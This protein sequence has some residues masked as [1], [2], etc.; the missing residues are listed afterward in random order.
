MEIQLQ[1]AE[2]CMKHPTPHLLSNNAVP[3]MNR[4]AQPH[5]S[6][7]VLP[8]MSSNVPPATRPAP[9]SSAPP[10]MYNS[11][12]EEVGMAVDTEERGVQVDMETVEEVQAVERCLNSHAE[13][14]QSG[15]LCKTARGFQRKTANRYQE[16]TA[17]GFPNKIADLCQSRN[18]L[19]LLDKCAVEVMEEA[20]ALAEV[21]VLEVA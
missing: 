15:K 2:L 11:A 5:M 13:V 6:S 18:Q 19:R 7:S 1:N 9:H 14:F 10:P 16:K 21:E 17:R 20:V 8:L 4:L 12:V 3:P